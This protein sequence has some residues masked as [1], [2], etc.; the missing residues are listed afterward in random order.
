MRLCCIGLCIGIGLWLASCNVLQPSFP[1]V[2]KGDTLELPAECNL[3]KSASSPASQG[4]KIPSF[5]K[6]DGAYPA[7]WPDPVKLPGAH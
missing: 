1:P 3:V 4:V 6:F 5:K 2:I 7:G